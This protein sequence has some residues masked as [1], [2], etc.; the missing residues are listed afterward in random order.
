MGMSVEEQKIEHQMNAQPNRNNSSTS[1]F[2]SEDTN[3]NRPRS[4]GYTS[5]NRN[6]S[7]TRGLLG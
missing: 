3:N 5:G 4:R 7:D 2:G 1:L 6:I